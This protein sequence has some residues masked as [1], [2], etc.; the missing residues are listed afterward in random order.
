MLHW[1]VISVPDTGFLTI[2]SFTNIS[3]IFMFGRKAALCEDD[4]DDDLEGEEDSI[5]RDMWV[6]LFDLLYKYQA[7]GYTLLGSRLYLN[8]TNMHIVQVV[9]Q[10]SSHIFRT[11]FS[12]TLIIQT[13]FRAEFCNELSMPLMVN[14][15]K[16]LYQN[17]LS[18]TR[19]AKRKRDQANGFGKSLGR[20]NLLFS[21]AFFSFTLPILE[22]L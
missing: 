10:V 20:T 9:G 13:S 8:R 17:C 21:D 6:A 19:N 4:S 1:I 15:L 7:D 11:W 22:I 5:L 18:N 12:L 2:H 3:L 16:P 14:S